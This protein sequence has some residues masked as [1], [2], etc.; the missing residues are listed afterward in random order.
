MVGYILM[1]SSFLFYSMNLSSDSFCFTTGKGKE[2]L[3]EAL[4]ADFMLQ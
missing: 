4:L 3:Q 1:K 2:V